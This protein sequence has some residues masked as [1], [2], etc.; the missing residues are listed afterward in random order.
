MSLP[1][2]KERIKQAC[3]R[4]ERQPSEVQLIAVSKGHSLEQIQ[5]HILSYG[6]FALGENRV[7]EWRDKNAARPEIEWH[8]IGNL[9]RNKV[10]YCQNISLFHSVNSER[11]AN[12]INKRAEQW[13]KVVNVLLEINVAAEAS[14]EGASLNEAEALKTHLQDLPHLNL[15]GL[16]TMAPYDSN[17]ENARPYFRRLREL[18]DAWGLQELSMGMSGDFEVAIEEGSTMVRIGS[19]LFR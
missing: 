3:Q 1:D 11:L 2:I 17:P 4:S 5:Q 18:R 13:G 19:A 9:Q 15:R 8:F 12:E 14:K 6:T 7:Q 16:M 10:K